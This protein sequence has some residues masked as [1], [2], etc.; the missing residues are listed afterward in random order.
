MGTG[1]KYIWTCCT[2]GRALGDA[3]AVWAGLSTAAEYLVSA[4]AVCILSL[5]QVSGSSA[6]DLIS[7]RDATSLSLRLVQFLFF[8]LS[9]YLFIF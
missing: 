3:D 5:L 4:Q 8:F 1:T 2:E 9:D 6:D 7:L